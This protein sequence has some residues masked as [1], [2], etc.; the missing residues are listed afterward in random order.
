MLVT[1]T[2]LK[3]E[4]FVEGSDWQT[5]KDRKLTNCLGVVL[6][7]NTNRETHTHRKRRREEKTTYNDY[8]N[9][10]RGGIEGEE[11]RGGIWPMYRSFV[12]LF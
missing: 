7:R 9:K 3:E 1:W 12:V 10:E 2:F 6:W 11:R 5:D 4:R 8:N